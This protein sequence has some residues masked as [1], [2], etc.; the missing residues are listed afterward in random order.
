M[1]K[2]IGRRKILIPVVAV[3]LVM[4][5]AYILISFHTFRQYEIRDLEDYS[6]GLTGLIAGD[7][8]DVEDIDGYLEQG[9]NYPGY[10]ETEHKLYLLREAYPDI[11]YLYV[12]QVREDGF[13]VVFD[14]NTEQ[15]A[16]SEPGTV[17]PFF[18]AY[19]PYIPDLLVGKE[20]PSIE[21]NEKYG[22]VL[23]VLTPVRDAEGNCRCYVGADSS[24]DMLREYTWNV[25][26]QVGLIFL[27]VLGIILAVSIF[28]T[29][30]GVI[31]KMDKLE[32][33]AYQDTLTGLQNRT[34]YYDYNDVLNKK[35]DTGDADFSI[36]MIDINF[37]KRMND[38]YGHEQGNLYLQHAANLIRK[39]F[40]EE[41]VYRIGGDEFA[42][43]LEGKAQEGAEERIRAFKEEAAK[44]QA[45]DSLQP[46]EKV[47]AAAGIAKYEKGR[48]ASTEEV[49]RRAD[50]AMYRDK[51]AMKAV[52]TD[53]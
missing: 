52:R 8:I 23:T 46:W 2:G 29:D 5:A 39:V 44:L 12:Y 6:K 53:T 42:V 33:R 11:V 36:V 30:R 22:H 25:I 26:S 32:D 51:I 45:D 50:E 4:T 10:A 15:F 9:R 3:L 27:I 47:S 19:Q 49:L 17:E 20:V 38:T 18:P 41:H 43:I 14:L 7:I 24:M 31:R 28:A 37:L 1:K 35:E 48:D 34:A 21:S 40:E 16:G 13:H